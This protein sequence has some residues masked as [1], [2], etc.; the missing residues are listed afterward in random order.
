MPVAAFCASRTNMTCSKPFFLYC[1]ETD[2]SSSFLSQEND[3]YSH[4][5]KRLC[6]VRIPPAESPIRFDLHYFKVEKIKDED[7]VSIKIRG[8]VKDASKVFFEDNRLQFCRVSQILASDT[9]LYEATDQEC[10]QLPGLLGCNPEIRNMMQVF[11][12]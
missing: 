4:T 6:L 10:I 8:N 1:T 2:L 5:E 3:D 9:S 12:F 11:L 7:R